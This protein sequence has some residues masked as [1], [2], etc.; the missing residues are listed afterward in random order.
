MNSAFFS[1]TKR[2]GGVH[3]KACEEIRKRAGPDLKK[4]DF[5]VGAGS[6]EARSV[7]TKG[8]VWSQN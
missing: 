8:R 1:R 3:Y 2:R 6:S 4:V 7:L 5:G